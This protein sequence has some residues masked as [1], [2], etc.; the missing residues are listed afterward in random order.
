MT[1]RP[2]AVTTAS[3]AR[4]RRGELRRLLEERRQAL[5]CQVRN[6][7]AHVRQERADPG[8]ADGADESEVSES[9][10]QEEIGLALTQIRTEAIR[11]ITEALEHLDTG[12]YGRCD[13]CGEDISI[14]RLRAV[15]FA[16]RC[17]DC[18]QSHEAATTRVRTS[19]GRRMPAFDDA[20]DGQRW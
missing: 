20:P 3:S 14:R 16:V 18:E 11:R 12:Q 1:P 13:E 7:L 17:I 5:L 2:S 15:P 9:G 19:I 6:H 4:A 8:H 10:V